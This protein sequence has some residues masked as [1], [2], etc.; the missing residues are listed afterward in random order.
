MHR[1]WLAA[2]ALPLLIVGCSSDTG[3]G[4]GASSGAVSS[5]SAQTASPQSAES[6]LEAVRMAMGMENL[7]AITMNGTAWRIR[8]SFM[9]TPNASPPW[10]SRDEI[11][12]YT[13]TIDLTQ[14][15]SSATGE[16][17]ASDLF[18][19]PPTA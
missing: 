14:P 6:V 15:V 8:N 4:A 5:A 7:E 9:Q 13:R 17:F 11:T 12:N 19:N 3:G 18:L 10:P 2:A 1:T 16:T